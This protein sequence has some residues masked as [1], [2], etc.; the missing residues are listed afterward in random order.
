MMLSKG[1]LN[2]AQYFCKTASPVLIP[3][4]LSFLQ[5]IIQ[6]MKDRGQNCLTF[7]WFILRSENERELKYI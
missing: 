1:S 5:L 6:K 7:L 3:Y 2:N 4:I